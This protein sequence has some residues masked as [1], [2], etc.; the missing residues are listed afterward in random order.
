MGQISIADVNQILQIT[1]PI[2]LALYVVLGGTILHNIVRYICKG[3]QLRSF[4][5]GFLY[6]LILVVILVRVCWFSLILHLT[7]SCMPDEIEDN[8]NL[9]ENALSEFI[10]LLDMTATYGELLIGMQQASAMAELYL[11][12]KNTT[13]VFG[14]KQ[15]TLDQT[16]DSFYH[17]RHSSYRMQ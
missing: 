7:I 8:P 3:Q 15:K 16:T 2:M 14:F 5:V 9:T 10:Y 1:I 4:Q 6:S 12:I 11:L 13:L 17:N